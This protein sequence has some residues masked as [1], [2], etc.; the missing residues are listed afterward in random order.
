MGIAAIL[1]TGKQMVSWVHIDDLCRLY[2][3]AVENERLSGVYNA[4]APAPAS[5]KTLTLTLAKKRNGVFY[6]PVHIPSFVLKLMLG[7]RSVEILKDL[8]VSCK[9]ILATGFNFRFATIGEALD[10]LVNI[11]DLR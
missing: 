9:K 10:D 8:T 2:L 4:V 11:K 1:G 3:S 6:I 5:N 7:T